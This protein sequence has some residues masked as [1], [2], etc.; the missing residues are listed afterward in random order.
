MFRSFI[1][2]L[3]M[4]LAPAAFAQEREWLL[5]AQDEDVYLLF[6]VPETDDVALSFWCK[7][8]SGKLKLFVPQGG[9]SAKRLKDMSFQIII[10]DKA[11]NFVGTVTEDDDQQ[12]ASIE[13][14]LTTDHSVL[15]EL[16]TADRFSVISEKRTVTVPLGEADIAGLLKLCGAK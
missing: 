13:T 12:T 15:G 7:I 4:L 2:I 1:I 11:H 5:D 8:G 10:G 9:W 16:K 14:E 6:G 3:S